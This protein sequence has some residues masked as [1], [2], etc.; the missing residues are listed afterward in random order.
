MIHEELEKNVNLHMFLN[1]CK[2]V[3]QFA[4]L[5]KILPSKSRV[6]MQSSSE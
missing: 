5:S 1:E 3:M 4:K 6:V 2:V